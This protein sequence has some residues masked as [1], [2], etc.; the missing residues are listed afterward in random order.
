MKG[1]ILAGDSGN[2]LHPLTIAIPKQLLPVYDKPMVY[3]PLKTLVEAEIKEIMVIT[4]SEHQPLFKKQ[5]GDGSQFGAVFCY[6]VQDE[7]KGIAEALTI[8]KNFID[9]TGVC[10]ITG[11]T[12]LVGSD[13]KPYIDQAEK[14][15][16]I[17][18]SATIFVCNDSDKEQYGKVE[19]DKDGKS[20]AIVGTSNCNFNN[21][22]VGLYVYPADAVKNAETIEPSERGRL[23]ITSLNQIYLQKNRLQILML[24]SNCAW[25][26]TNSA[27]TILA[28]GNYVKNNNLG[29][30]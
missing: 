20:K 17:S 25:L 24:D 21:S 11:D 13:L 30:S 12:I 7:P 14:A 15:V 5:L 6:A 23:E 1:I 27:E 2:R 18:G 16:R 28:A 3:Y 9:K 26:D 10:L 29:K 4:T 22:I 8:A 19:K